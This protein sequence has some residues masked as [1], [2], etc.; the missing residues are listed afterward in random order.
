MLA[1]KHAEEFEDSFWDK[2]EFKTRVHG[3]SGK[4]QQFIVASIP[5]VDETPVDTCGPMPCKMTTHGSLLFVG[6]GSWVRMELQATS[7][8]CSME[9]HRIPT[10]FMLPEADYRRRLTTARHTHLRIF[11]VRCPDDKIRSSQ[12][13]VGLYRARCLIFSS[14]VTGRWRGFLQLSFARV[15][16]SE[17]LACSPPTKTIRVKS[18]AGSL[19][20]FACGNRTGRCRWSA[21]FLG[22]LPFPPAL[23]FRRCSILNSIT[24]IGSQDLDVKSRPNLFPSL[25]LFIDIVCPNHVRF[26]RKGRDLTS[27]QQP[28]EKRRRL[29]Y[30]QYCELQPDAE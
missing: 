3:N 25:Q 17:W 18:P 14:P 4:V 27:T 30:I 19:R 15:R 10:M 24:P 23:S 26:I 11:L 16:V 1:V 2:L 12:C 20:I 6:A 5:Q 28:M 29:R 22:D 8:K 21:G 9:V 13:Y 7:Y